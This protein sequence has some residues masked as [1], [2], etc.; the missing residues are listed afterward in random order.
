MRIGISILPSAARYMTF[1]Q[2]S[3]QHLHGSLVVNEGNWDESPSAIG[4]INGYESVLDLLCNRFENV[5]QSTLI[6]DFVL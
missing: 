3:L 1:S 6:A 4:L 5:L 2:R